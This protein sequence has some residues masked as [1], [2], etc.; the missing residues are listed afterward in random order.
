MHEVAE[1]LDDTF[2]GDAEVYPKP[3]NR[4]ILEPYNRIILEPYNPRTLEP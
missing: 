2:L 4:I 3:Y 1:E